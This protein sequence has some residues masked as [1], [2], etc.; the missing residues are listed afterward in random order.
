ML[1]LAVTWRSNKSV[2][3]WKGICCTGSATA[4]AGPWSSGA[5]R[6]TCGDRATAVVLILV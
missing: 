1:Q 4:V 5:G 6:I 3:R 2:A